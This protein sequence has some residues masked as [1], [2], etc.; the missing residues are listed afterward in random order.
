MLVLETESPSLQENKP[1]QPSQSKVLLFPGQPHTQAGKRVLLLIAT[2]GFCH[3][4]A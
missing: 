3:C 4:H 2:L 1:S